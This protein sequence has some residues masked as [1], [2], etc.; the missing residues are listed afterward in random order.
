MKKIILISIIVVL[1]LVAI[2]TLRKPSEEKADV[3]D[4][5]CYPPY[6][7][8]GNDCCTDMN[9]NNQCDDVEFGTKTQE[10]AT[11]ESTMNWSKDDDIGMYMEDRTLKKKYITYPGYQYDYSISDGGFE[12]YNQSIV[13]KGKQCHIRSTREHIPT[14]EMQD[15]WRPFPIPCVET[16]D[17]INFIEKNDPRL[18]MAYIDKWDVLCIEHLLEFENSQFKEYQSTK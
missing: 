15:Y 11:R 6:I 5:D 2:F 13:I 8:R 1:L 10:E 12:G 17:C 14:A 7:K 3:V 16:T 18:R 4:K 9:K